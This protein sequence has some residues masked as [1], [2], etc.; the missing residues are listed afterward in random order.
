M[1]SVD[2]PPLVYE[3][4]QYALVIVVGPEGLGQRNKQFAFN[5]LGCFQTAEDSHRFAKRLNDAGYDMFDMYTVE[6]RQFLPMPPPTAAELEDVH[7]GDQLLDAIMSEQRK[8]IDHSQ[9]TI[10]RNLEACSLQAEEARQKAQE[11]RKATADERKNI[12]CAIGEP[13]NTPP[14]GIEQSKI[15]KI[16]LKQ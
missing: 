14:P 2:R 8:K 1:S 6:T 3:G 16:S 4:Q 12:R 7:Y 13:R 9:K 5:V 15:Q 10:E 11:T